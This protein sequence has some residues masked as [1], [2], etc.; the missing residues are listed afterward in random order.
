MIED[1]ETVDAINERLDELDFQCFHSVDAIEQKLNDIFEDFD[2]K[3]PGG[4]D[5]EQDNIFKIK[6]SG[7][8]ETDLFLYVTVDEEMVGYSIFAQILEQEDIEEIQNTLDG[9]NFFEDGDEEE[10]EQ[11]ISPFL[12]RVRHSADD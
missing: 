7:N 3:F 6:T 8:T 2:V 4:I 5:P 11:Q 12:L 10:E 9:F 1:Y